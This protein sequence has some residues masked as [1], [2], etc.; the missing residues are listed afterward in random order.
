RQAVS[1]TRQH[2][3]SSAGEGGSKD[4]QQKPQV[5]NSKNLKKTA[6]SRKYAIIQLLNHSTNSPK[7]PN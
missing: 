7:P 4:N 6:F 3:L 2:R 1:P 5:E